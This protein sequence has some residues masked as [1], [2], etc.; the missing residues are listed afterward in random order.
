MPAASVG[1]VVRTF[2]ESKGLGIRE[3]D[4]PLYGETDN[5]IT[6]TTIHSAKGLE[7]RVVFWCD[8]TRRGGSWGQEKFLLGRDGFLLGDPERKTKEQTREYRDLHKQLSDEDAAETKRLWYVAATRAMDL[9]IL[10]AVPQGRLRSK[11]S[12]AAAI[13]NCLPSLDEPGLTKLTFE[14]ADG[15]T[16]EAAVH[17]ASEGPPGAAVPL[18]AAEEPADLSVP[19]QHI[20]VPVSRPRHSATEYLAHT[21]CP[22]KHWFKYVKG[23]REPDIPSS[24][25]RSFMMYSS[26]CRNRTNSINCWKTPSAGGMPTLPHRKGA[27]ATAIAHISGRKSSPSP[28]M[29]STER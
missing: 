13:K 21:R 6:L 17:Y 3:G 28:V 4:A 14:A 2:R 29:P 5:V 25:A 26:T 16:H 15:S 20:V 19:A 12:P 23:V 24:A 11:D 1:E 10:P 8:L 7:W 18:E 22:K 9:L 27:K